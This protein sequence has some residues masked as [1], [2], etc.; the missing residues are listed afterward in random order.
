[1]FYWAAHTGC[2]QNQF[3]GWLQLSSK[4]QVISFTGWYID[5]EKLISNVNYISVCFIHLRTSHRSHRYTTKTMTNCKFKHSI[6]INTTPVAWQCMWPLLVSHDPWWFIRPQKCI[7]W[8]EWGG[9]GVSPPLQTPGG[10]QQDTCDTVYLKKDTSVA[11]GFFVE[12]LGREEWQ[13]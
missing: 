8:H 7:Q 4:P 5:T 13:G 2:C 6:S 12:I 1:M 3:V 10:C 9:R 11:T